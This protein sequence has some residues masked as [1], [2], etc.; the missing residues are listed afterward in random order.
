LA[1]KRPFERKEHSSDLSIHT[2]G[3]LDHSPE[4][5]DISLAIRPTK[6]RVEGT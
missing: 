4:A 2:E 5:S 1:S 3:K 6:K